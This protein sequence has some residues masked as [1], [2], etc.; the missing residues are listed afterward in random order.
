M[1]RLSTLHGWNAPQAH[2]LSGAE[3]SFESWLFSDSVHKQRMRLGP[4]L[5]N[6]NLVILLVARLPSHTDGRLDWCLASIMFLQ[7]FLGRKLFPDQ[8]TS[9]CRGRKPSRAGSSLG[10][11]SVSSLVSLQLFDIRQSIS[12]GASVTFNSTMRHDVRRSDSEIQL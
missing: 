9:P 6:Y 4:D 7:C 2:S 8:I 12:G 1:T 5:T 3:L 11:A 10:T